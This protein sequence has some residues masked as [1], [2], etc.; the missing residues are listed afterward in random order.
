MLRHSSRFVT[1]RLAPSRLISTASCLKTSDK[2]VDPPVEKP[3]SDPGHDA[4]TMF[5][6][7]HV[8]SKFE[9]RILVWT[10]RFKTDR[11]IPKEV[12][13]ELIEKAKSKARIKVANYMM[14]ATV[15]ACFYQI[16]SGKRALER[17]ETVAKMNLDWH[18][19]INAEKD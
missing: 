15:I 18:K 12:S 8:P 19:K 13:I 14:L 1:G 9:R 5:R 17:G 11:E 16:W 6:K 2:P 7:I 3:S 10:G 4:N